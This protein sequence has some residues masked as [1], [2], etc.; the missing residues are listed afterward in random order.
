MT[1]KFPCSWK[2]LMVMTGTLWGECRGEPHEAKI[3]VAWVIRNRAQKG[4]RYGGT[5]RD[6]CLKPKQFSSWNA[7]DPNSRKVHK[8]GIEW[9][10]DDQDWPAVLDCLLASLLVVSGK[11]VD[12]TSESTHYHTHFVNPSWSKNKTPA[13]VIGAHRFFNNID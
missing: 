9:S 11:A 6:V 13:A 2:D 12:P 7:A 5:I 10:Y 1:T 4:G 8:I 3:A